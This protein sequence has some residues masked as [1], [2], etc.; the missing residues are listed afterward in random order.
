[1]PDKIIKNVA[2]A[3]SG[4][5]RYAAD[6]LPNLGLKLPDSESMSKSSPPAHRSGSGFFNVYRP[7]TVL[8]RAVD[9]F[10]RLPLTLEHPPVMIDGNNFKTYSVGFT[11][12]KADVSTT[13]DGK[14]ITIHSTLTVVDNSAVRAYY[15]GVVEVSPG[16]NAEFDWED[17]T[18]PNGEH[19]DIVM[20]EITNVNHLAM[21]KHG[22]GGT[23]AC[24]LDHMGVSMKRKSGLMYAVHKI[25]GVKD[26][27]KPFK[28]QVG[29]L[30]K[31]R[32]AID[33]SEVTRRVGCLKDS[34]S[35]LPESAGRDKLDRFIDDMSRI[36]EESDEAANKIGEIVSG[37]YDSLD[38]EAVKEVADDDEGHEKSETKAE[39]KKEEHEKSESPSKEKKEEAKTDDDDAKMKDDDDDDDK[40]KTK[41]DDDKSK[42]KDDDTSKTKDDDDKSKTKDDDDDDDKKDDDKSHIT[43]SDISAILSKDGDLSSSD[44]KKVLTHI[45][46]SLP[47]KNVKDSVPEVKTGE[48]QKVLD[49]F[50]NKASSS[51]NVTMDSSSSKSGTIANLLKDMKEGK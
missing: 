1:M 40:S 17:G 15:N 24:I 26:S 43:D 34:I 39:E 25:L 19:Y 4:V 45:C 6:E 49:S 37:L 13:P 28:A 16:Y 9:K 44:L 31:D 27:A 33:D 32:N 42:T 38:A 23:V 3:R 18:A 20:K 35:D 36:R 22:R 50:R 2:I 11:G 14:E 5:Y 48:I 51:V 46:D 30:I 21:C 12:D 7:A 8:A 41:D 29:E 47:K 10:V